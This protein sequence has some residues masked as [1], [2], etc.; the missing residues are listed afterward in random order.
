MLFLPPRHGKSEMVTVRYPVWL[1]EREP[2]T[3]VIVGAYNQTLV[4]KFSRK[5]RRIATGRVELSEDR[6]AVEDWETETGGG[7]R[8]VGVGGGITGQGGHY[9]IIDDPVKSR[10]EANSQAYRDRVW[11]WYKDDLYTR[12]EPGGVIILIM[13]RWH[14]DDLA[15]RIIASEDVSN[16]TVLSLPALAKADDPLG[17]E[18]GVALCP[19]RF[20]EAALAGI[21]TVLGNSFY[22][23]YQQTPQPPE[24]DFFKRVWFN[25]FVDAAPAYFEALVRYW[26]KASS[27]DGD[28]TAGVLMGRKDGLYYVVDIVRGRWEG[29]DREDIIKQTAELD[30]L[31]YRGTKIWLEQEGGSSGKD[32]AGATIRN[33]AGF[34]VYAEHPTGDKVT[35][36]EPF[37][38]Q[39]MAGNVR[40]VRG[41]WIPAYLT[42][43]SSFPTGAYDDQ[44]DASSGAFNKVAATQ[45]PAGLTV[46]DIPPEETYRTRRRRR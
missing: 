30:K 24:G 17:R 27:L 41:E 14:E 12:L 46:T 21:K 9:I 13:T 35:R 31:K 5:S 38:A 26:D 25:R 1:L 8:A 16:W 11:D 15:G 33:L 32:S 39:A 19:D 23:L 42:E 43:L 6:R 45:L 18:K 2:S 4:N 44:V 3:R 34:P 36:A 29:S 28:Y 20:D 7:F 22:A 10:E 37:Q 40:L